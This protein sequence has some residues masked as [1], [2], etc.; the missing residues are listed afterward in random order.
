MNRA[1]VFFG[2]VSHRLGQRSRQP[3]AHRPWRKTRAPQFRLEM[4]EPRLLLSATLDPMSGVLHVDGTTDPD[5]IQ[6]QQVDIDGDTMIRVSMDG[7]DS[8]FDDADVDGLLVQGSLGDDEITIEA[9]DRPLTKGV[10]VRGFLEVG[11][12][13]LHLQWSPGP[14]PR[15]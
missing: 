2:K 9:I 1:A 11:S 8:D 7:T 10:K 3:Q 15:R 13:L 6:I 14:Q 12:T 4:L 5:V